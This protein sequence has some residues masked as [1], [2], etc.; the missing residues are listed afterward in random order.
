MKKI[1]IFF[2]LLS[3]L[4]IQT[5]MTSCHK[6]EPV[7]LTVSPN[8]LELL[9]D[10]GSSVSFSIT[11]NSDWYISGLPDW[12]SLSAQSGTS[13]GSVTITALST[14]NSSAERS[15]ELIV[16]AGDKSSVV[17]VRQR[18]SLVAN[19]KV[20]F[21][22]MLTMPTSIAFK[23]DIDSNVSYFYA[24]YLSANAAGWTDEK[25]VNT[26]MDEDRFD[27]NSS[28]DTGLQG[29]GGMDS[30]TEYY[31]C[32]VGFNEKGEQGELT[33]T[34]IRTQKSLSQVPKISIYDVSYSSTKW[35]WKTEPNS[36][37]SKYYMLFT[38]GIY[39]DYYGLILTEAEICWIIKDG[40]GKGN[41]APIAK[42]GEWSGAR[43]S[44]ETSV[45]I[46]TWGVDAEN[47]FS[48]SCTE[49]YG[50]IDSTRSVVKKKFKENKVHRGIADSFILEL[51]KYTKLIERQ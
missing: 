24:G 2:S 39:A 29:F 41:M 12:L 5:V 30:D 28:E 27:P 50:T 47:T 31:L 15:T 14:N 17:S 25:I 21:K 18:A 38:E 43:D 33:K 44:G 34:L 42:S 48:T 45:Y 49:Y 9:S 7:E 22:D 10:K 32:A 23:Y 4:S 26:L 36:Y 20:S 11:T 13:N 35:R 16:S 6:D 51:Q 40:I 46:A 19:C 1:H 8:S 3:C 37:T